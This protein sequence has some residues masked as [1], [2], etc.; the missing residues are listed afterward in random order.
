M[1]GRYRSF[2]DARAF[3]QRLRLR[4]V[5]HYWSWCAGK[6]NDLVRRPAD[7]PATPHQV[8][9]DEWVSFSDY[10]G[11]K[12]TATFRRKFLPFEEARE[13]ARA[14]CLDSVTDW[15]EYA[16][17]RLHVPGMSPRP[18]NI[19]SNPNFTY[20]KTGWAGGA[21]WLGYGD[22][23]EPQLSKFRPFEAARNF[24]RSLSLSGWLEW[25]E[26][27]RS[28]AKPADIPAIPHSAYKGH[29]WIDY[30]DWLGTGLK[31][32]HQTPLLS[33]NA[34]HDFVGR[35]GVKNQHEWRDYC[36]G[37]LAHLGPKPINIPANPD[38]AYSTEWQGW[39]YW[40][41]ARKSEL[42]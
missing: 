28:S 33:F 11:T 22:P 37:K 38:K 5:A 6:E 7:I 13:F 32:Y 2:E 31:A 8:Y 9:K 27:V 14:L 15:E 23:T 39:H 30:G 21:D 26:Y 35:L 12:R 34:A 10:L 42:T 4:S 1:T 3:V 18:D 25:R 41:S 19:P 16:C 29:G 36:N 20:K 17:G 24:A 40:F